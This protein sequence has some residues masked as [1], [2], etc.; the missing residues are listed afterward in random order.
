MIEDEDEEGNHNTHSIRS[1]RSTHFI[2]F[3]RSTPITHTFLGI[4]IL[5]TLDMEEVIRLNDD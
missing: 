1:T 5:I 2:H 4:H 3:S